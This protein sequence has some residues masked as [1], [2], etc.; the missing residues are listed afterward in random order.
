MKGYRFYEELNNKN[1]KAEESKGIVVAVLLTGN[2]RKQRPLRVDTNSVECIAGVFDS[3]NSP[4]CHTSA[5]DSYLWE[6]CRRI[7]EEKARQ[8]HPAL[9]TYL[10]N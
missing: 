9:F 5:G 2:G 8:I 6:E 7:S 1:R 3:P 10:D 4:V